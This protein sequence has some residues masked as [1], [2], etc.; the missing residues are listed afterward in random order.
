MGMYR[1]LG[2]FVVWAGLV[3]NLL[4]GCGS[5]SDSSPKNLDGKNP[6]TAPTLIGEE[7]DPTGKADIPSEG[8]DSQ[9][10]GCINLAN[11]E[12]STE[13]SIEKGI[14][15]IGG[16]QGTPTLRSDRVRVYKTPG[17]QAPVS[18]GPNE[19]F[20]V[21]GTGL[22]N[23]TE[24]RFFVIRDFKQLP[25]P[26]VVAESGG[27]GN[28]KL[29]PVNKSNGDTIVYKT[30]PDFDKNIPYAIWFAD[31]EG[32]W[33]GPLLLN[34]PMPMWLSP[35]RTVAA[36]EDAVMPPST[37]SNV[38]ILGRNL[39]SGHTLPPCIRL[40]GENLY[41]FEAED[42]GRG[43][44][45]V[46]FTVPFLVLPGSYTVEVS[47]DRHNWLRLA[48]GHLEVISQPQRTEFPIDAYGCSGTDDKDDIYCIRQAIRAAEANGGGNVVFP[49]GSWLLTEPA[50]QLWVTYGDGII[51]P[52]GVSLIGQS[53]DRSFVIQGK[54]WTQRHS[55][56]FTLLGSNRVSDLT[57]KRHEPLSTNLSDGV[58]TLRLGAYLS[59]GS[60]ASELEHVASSMIINSNKFVGISSAIISSG[61]AVSDIFIS[62]NHFVVHERGIGLGGNSFLGKHVYFMV[63]D[64][65]IADNNFIPGDFKND[66]QGPIALE[67]GGS[68]RLRVS[69][70]RI[71]GHLNGGWRS[72][73]FWHQGGVNNLIMIDNNF[74][75]CTGDK[76]G[77]GEAITFDSNHGLVRYDTEAKSYIADSVAGFKG[78]VTPSSASAY[79]I[80]VSAER[81]LH[82]EK[83]YRDHWVLVV[84]GPGTGQARKIAS[85]KQTP[86]TVTFNLIPGWDVAPT[87]GKSKLVV[88]RAYWQAQIMDNSVDNTG[89]AKP[90]QKGLINWFATTLDSRIAGNQ[91]KDTEGI[92]LWGLYSP[93]NP[94]TKPNESFYSGWHSCDVSSNRIEGK[95]DTELYGG[96]T[97]TYGTDPSYGPALGSSI[98]IKGNTISVVHDRSVALSSSWWLPPER[99]LEW[100]IIQNNELSRSKIGVEMENSNAHNTV[101]FGNIFSV[102]KDRVVDMATETLYIRSNGF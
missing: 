66:N 96:I 62:D 54:G 70:N 35:R 27:A 78:V 29:S 45:A 74:L 42:K 26:M 67:I 20:V 46:S 94:S 101:L 19:I 59:K 68:Q 22:D 71:D 51:I 6:T 85:V 37:M 43:D 61:Q 30:P 25:G 47:L 17:Y 39:K 55:A 69:N 76:A 97:L 99:T 84:D 41:V 58:A 15:S 38:T 64:S 98:N 13:I 40:K 83:F 48:D 23:V 16:E 57:F 60:A 4:Y 49:E 2:L 7:S 91:M 82:D 52:E 100:T 8:G 32:A 9:V 44:Y 93:D 80:T 31:D 56:L 79:S 87:P 18:V 11:L 3:T 88:Y 89:C 28:G 14:V 92:L 86:G 90:G 77:D 75:S 12:Q 50:S 1:R 73:M 21:K 72:G 102:E 5:G 24:T 53:K 33:E 36:S 63:S 34:V 10:L 65:V 95:V 81:L